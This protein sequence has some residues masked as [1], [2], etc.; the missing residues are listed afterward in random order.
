MLFKRTEQAKHGLIHK[1]D[2]K[3]TVPDWNKT[4]AAQTVASITSLLIYPCSP[5]EQ[6]PAVNKLGAAGNMLIPVGQ[7]E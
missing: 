2:G 4:T 3:S 7:R 6:K 1:D 5:C